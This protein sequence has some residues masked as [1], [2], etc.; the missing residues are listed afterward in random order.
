MIHRFRAGEAH[1][2]VLR[3]EGGKF[4]LGEGSGPELAPS[5]SLTGQVPPISWSD[6]KGLILQP[7]NFSWWQTILVEKNLILFSLLEWA[8]LWPAELRARALGAP[9]LVG[10]PK[11]WV[12]VKVPSG[13]PGASWSAADLFWKLS[14]WQLMFIVTKIFFPHFLVGSLSSVS[15]HELTSSPWA[16]ILTKAGC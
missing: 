8:G 3:L 13:E 9:V 15:A 12:L 2:L 14:V 16:D 1:A 10:S 6:T 7:N 4:A 5:S 11:L